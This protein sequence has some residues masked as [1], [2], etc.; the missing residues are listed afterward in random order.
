MI[1]WDVK[2]Y[3]LGCLCNLPNRKHNNFSGGSLFGVEKG[4]KVTYCCLHLFTIAPHVHCILLCKSNKIQ[5]LVG[6][7]QAKL[8]LAV[9]LPGEWLAFYN[10]THFLKTQC[11]L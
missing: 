10:T 2:Y 4:G 3:H 5:A 8:A 6:G 11:L 1:C 7:A 9:T